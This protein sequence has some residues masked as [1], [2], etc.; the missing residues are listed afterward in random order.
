MDLINRKSPLLTCD[1]TTQG[2][3]DLHPSPNQGS[4]PSVPGVDY[5]MTV[6]TPGDGH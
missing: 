5:Y 4:N 2:N 3:K 6:Q 1:N